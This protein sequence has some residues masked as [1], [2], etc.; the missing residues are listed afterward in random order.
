LWNFLLPT[1]PTISKDKTKS[2]SPSYCN[3]TG[4]RKFY[5]RGCKKY[6]HYS[7]DGEVTNRFIHTKAAHPVA[8][9]SAYLEYMISGFSS[10]PIS[11]M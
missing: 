11:W 3:Q 7:L 1:S 9:K 4:N 2:S 10:D 6:T 8:R 5:S